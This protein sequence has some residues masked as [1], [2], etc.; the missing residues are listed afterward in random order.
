VGD[1]SYLRRV[2]DL[3]K[4]SSITRIEILLEGRWYNQ[5]PNTFD[6]IR[7]WT[8][9]SQAVEGIVSGIRTNST[10]YKICKVLKEVVGADAFCIDDES[11]YD[12]RSIIL[13]GKIAAELN[14]H[15]TLCPF[16]G[17]GFWGDILKA[18]DKKV[19][20]ALYLQCYDGG[21]RNNPADWVNNLKPS[22]PVY[23]IFLC[24]GAFSICGT[25]HNS[26]TPA[27]IKADMI[28][29]KQGYPGMS[30][31]AVWQVADVKSYVINKCAV[32]DPASGSATSVSEY[33][34]QIKGSLETGL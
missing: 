14:M 19:V 17:Y 2:A 30:G 23:P 21:I 11:V 12:S 28:R 10:L 31:A 34:Q 16:R 24:R 26:K 8:D 15:M 29:F 27:E 3:K 13:M 4:H 9:S 5:P 18:S 32:S 20:D 1:T 25:S 22:Q 6:F 33:L 7:D